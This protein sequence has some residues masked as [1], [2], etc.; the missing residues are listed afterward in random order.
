MK[1]KTIIS[2]E[3]PKDSLS[4]LNK[5][6]KRDSDCMSRSEYIRNAICSFAGEAIFS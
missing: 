5:A 4:K 1:D 2:F 3:I 6:W